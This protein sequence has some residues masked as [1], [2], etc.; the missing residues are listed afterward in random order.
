MRRVLFSLVFLGGIVAGAA[1][2]VAAALLRHNRK[3][4]TPPAEP[5]L[6]DGN[7]RGDDLRT[8]AAEFPDRTVAPEYLEDQ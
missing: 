6:P 7:S 8:W 5:P 3:S 2:I 1:A 4:A